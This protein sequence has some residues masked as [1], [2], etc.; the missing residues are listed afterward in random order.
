MP[1]VTKSLNF[2]EWDLSEQVEQSE[3]IFTVKRRLNGVA[4]VRKLVELDDCDPL[5]HGCSSVSPAKTQ[6]NR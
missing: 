3:D 4:T 1:P 2:S 6:E 5:P